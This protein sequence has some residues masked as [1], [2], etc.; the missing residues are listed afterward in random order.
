MT[1]ELPSKIGEVLLETLAKLVAQSEE[2]AS[3]MA[4]IFRGVNTVK[5]EVQEMRTEV[6]TLQRK[7]DEHLKEGAN[8]SDSA[9]EFRMVEVVKDM[10]T[11]IQ[12]IQHRAD[13]RAA[14]IAQ[15]LT[16]LHAVTVKAEVTRDPAP[17]VPDLSRVLAE[18]KT[19]AETVRGSQHTFLQD[20]DREHADREARGKNIRISGLV[21][22]EGEDTLAEVSKL[23]SDVMKVSSQGLER[24][25]A[26]VRNDRRKNKGRGHGGICVWTILQYR[27][28]GQILIAG[29]FNSRVGTAQGEGVVELERAL[30]HKREETDWKRESEDCGSNRFADYFLQLVNLC[31]LTVLN[32]TKGFPDT[33]V[34]TCKTSLGASVIDF[35]L[36]SVGVRERISKFEMGDFLPESDHRPLQWTV[37]GFTKR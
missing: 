18:M 19:Y 8:R 22:V 10:Q 23:F 9:G 11:E 25:V 13:D 35:L 2:S 6:R 28:K 30:W 26:A 32:G 24:A 14:E 37:S 21:E 36:A 5:I 33:S 1:E 15:Q 17:P 29:D 16:S 31:E 34:F 12:S 27:E 3:L 4:N 7:L 20:H